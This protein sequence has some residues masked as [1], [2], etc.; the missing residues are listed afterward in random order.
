MKKIVLFAFLLIPMLFFANEEFLI[1]DPLPDAP[2]LAYRGNYSVG[3]RTLTIIDEDRLDILNYSENNPNPT[4]DRPLT[5][6]VWYPCEIGPGRIEKTV[7][8]DEQFVDDAIVFTGRALRNAKPVVEEFPL[9]IVSHGYPG[10]RFMMSY[11]TENL[12]SKGYVVAAISHTESTV[13]DQ[14][15][16]SS[17]LL[18]RPLDVL[19]TLDEIERLSKLNDSFLFNL[20]DT[21]N[22]GLVGYSMGGYG[23]INVAGA[24]F[25]EAGVNLAW[26]VPGGHLSIRQSGNPEYEATFDERIK[27]I[28]AMAPWGAGLFWDADTMKG[29]KVPSFFVSGNYDD[30]AGYENGVK[31]F[32][33]RAINSERYM[34]VFQNARHNVAPN[35]YGVTPLASVKLNDEGFIRYNEPSWDNR[36]LNNVV[37]HFA[38]A[39][40]G[41]YLQGN[42]YQTY[43]DL[44]AQS[45]QGV[46][47]QNNDGTFKE[48]HTHWKGFPPRTAL[49]MEF[50]SSQP[51]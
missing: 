1:G 19:F 29:L 16:F 38:T 36:K 49:G 7:Y 41:E 4:Y 34:L 21:D 22:V 51:E 35:A 45:N 26:G 8:V 12:A 15:S 39:F 6:E 3:V 30:V 40:F 9:I 32:Y 11:L 28:F 33:D 31:L 44:V 50:Y 37:Q 5:V 20:V 48:N 13:R 14:N 27:A 42:D 43:L 18:N 23:I 2:E 24:G 47:S 17:T 25:S 46:W 10:T